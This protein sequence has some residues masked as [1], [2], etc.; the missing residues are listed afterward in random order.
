MNSEYLAITAIFISGLY[1]GFKLKDA[2]Y[3]FRN[4][5]VRKGTGAK[6]KFF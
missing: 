4:Y 2:S 5:V 6:I 1:V 3:K